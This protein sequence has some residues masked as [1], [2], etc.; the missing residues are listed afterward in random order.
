VSFLVS[1]H[2]QFITKT[3][4]CDELLGSVENYKDFFATLEKTYSMTDKE[5]AGFDVCADDEE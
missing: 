1:K 5:F 2:K 4:V 3:N